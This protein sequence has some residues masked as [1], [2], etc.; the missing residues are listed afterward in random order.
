MMMTNLQSLP[1]RQAHLG[2]V[3]TR[4]HV[5]P[6]CPAIEWGQTKLCLGP[7]N[8]RGF[9]EIQINLMAGTLDISSETIQDSLKLIG[10]LT[11]RLH[12]HDK[13]FDKHLQAVN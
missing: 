8:A 1:A 9:W 6:S 3:R 13:L 11:L 2:L 12:C 7:L 10:H 4:H 5:L